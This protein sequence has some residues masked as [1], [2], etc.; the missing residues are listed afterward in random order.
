VPTK[1][2]RVAEQA[3][4]AFT[5]HEVNGRFLSDTIITKVVKGHENMNIKTTFM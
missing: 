3:N 5:D 2:L 1:A 4:V